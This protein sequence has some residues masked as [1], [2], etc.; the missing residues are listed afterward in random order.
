M[1][2]KVDVAGKNEIEVLG[3]HFNINSYADEGSIKTHCLKA[4]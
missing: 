2:F 1:P 4:V 3:T